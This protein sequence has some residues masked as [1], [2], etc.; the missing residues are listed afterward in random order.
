MCHSANGDVTD[1]QGR[2][3]INFRIQNFAAFQLFNRDIN[4]GRSR[5]S[6]SLIRTSVDN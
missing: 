6:S 2:P 5:G 4:S 1:R 3:G